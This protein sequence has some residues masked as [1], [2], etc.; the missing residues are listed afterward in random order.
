MRIKQKKLLLKSPSKENGKSSKTHNK[1]NDVKADKNKTSNQSD[2]NSN[3][4]HQ[5]TTAVTDQNKQ[6]IQI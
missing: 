3:Q 6:K 4:Q 5:T 1:D 2:Q